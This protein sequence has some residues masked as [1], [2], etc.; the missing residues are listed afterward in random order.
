MDALKEPPEAGASGGFY[1]RR[2]ASRRC[3]GT[4][5]PQVSCPVDR[6]ILAIRSSSGRKAMARHFPEYTPA[7]VQARAEVST[8]WLDSATFAAHLSLDSR[9]GESLTQL[10]EA[11]CVL[12]AWMPEKDDYFYP[13]WQLSSSQRPSP[14]LA[15]LLLMLRGSYGVAE[16]APTSGWE[17]IEWL[18]APHALLGG[19]SPSSLLA[20]E[21]D[22]VLDAARQDFSSW[23]DDA[24]W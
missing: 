21:P 11:G 23:S 15:E 4:F 14:V 2:P 24:R 18:V 9:K 12:G 8:G 17:E 10:R 7:T 16:G 13:T 19:R 3:G 1:M 6:G 22:H 20:I 5:P